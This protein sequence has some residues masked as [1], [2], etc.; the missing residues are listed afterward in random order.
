MELKENFLPAPEL[1]I[2]LT[3][4]PE[5]DTP[6]WTFSST[7]GIFSSVPSSLL[8]QGAGCRANAI[9]SLLATSLCLLAAAKG[10]LRLHFSTG[11]CTEEKKDGLCPGTSTGFKPRTN[12]QPLNCNGNAFISAILGLLR[13]LGL[14]RFFFSLHSLG[15]K[16]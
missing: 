9:F 10:T 12:Y 15:F 1:A 5:Q 7:S 4:L 13:A 3:F 16:S 6:A 14:S 2:N 11:G 8:L